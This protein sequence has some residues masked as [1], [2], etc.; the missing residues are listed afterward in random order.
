V[1]PRRVGRLSLPAPY[2]PRSK[3][4]V[5]ET[6]A[7]LRR[8]R[9]GKGGA[10][11]DI[12]VKPGRGHSD[13]TAVEP[14]PT[15]LASAREEP[16]PCASCPDL[17]VH[18][19]AAQR[20][21]RLAGDIER[22]KRV[23]RGRTES[24]ARQFDRVLRVLE[25]YG[26]VE[27]WSITDA[28]EQLCGLYHECDLLVAE[29]LRAGL[30]D[31]LDPAAVSGLVSCFTYEARGPGGPPATPWFPSRRVRE[32][33][34]AIDQ[35]AT[36]LNR[37]EEDAGL[38][39]TRRPDATFL[40]LAYAWSAGEDLS[41][42][43]SDE[44]MSGGDFVR[45]IKQLVD[46]LRQIADLALTPATRRNARSAADA[47]FRGVVSASSVVGLDDGQ[48]VDIVDAEDEVPDVFDLAPPP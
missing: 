8:S 45:N 35:L 3:S 15:Q 17:K 20:A 22:L 28:G 47:V 38:P 41:D 18:L 10:G 2:E 23:I 48:R 7:M 43:L 9:Y 5:Q 1:P 39:M 21:E 13:E 4:F 24:L 30:L 40:P 42:V 44:E 12:V 34:L 26:Y 29:A 19:K 27:G 11:G 33:W 31:D 6:A 37:A 25:A 14:P 16:H 32:R 36:D 46:L